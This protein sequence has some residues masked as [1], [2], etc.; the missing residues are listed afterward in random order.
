MRTYPLLCALIALPLALRPAPTFAQD[1]A[2]ASAP[3]SGESPVVAGAKNVAIEKGEIR[4]DGRI[5]A[6]TGATGFDIKAFSFTTQ[7]GK[8]IEFD[9]AKD[10]SIEGGGATKIFAGDDLEKPLGWNVVKLGMRVAVIGKDTGSGKAL[11]VRAIVLSDFSSKYIAGRSISASAPVAALVRKGRQAFEGSDF[12]RAQK[13]FR[14]A[15][16]TGAG[17][18]DQSGVSLALSWEGSTFRELGQNEKAMQSLNEA[19]KIREALGDT[20]STGGILNNLALIYMATGQ[21]AQAVKLMERANENLEGE[22]EAVVTL[23][24]ANLGRAY[25]AN[26]QWSSG[27]EVFRG[28]IGRF[29]AAGQP[30]REVGAMLSISIALLAQGKAEEAATGLAQARARIETITEAPKKAEALMSLA[31]YLAQSKDKDGARTAINQAIES[32][33]AAGDSR[34]AERARVKLDTPDA[35]PAAGATGAAPAPPADTPATAP[36]APADA[37]ATAP[38]APADAPVPPAPPAAAGG[39]GQ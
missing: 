30:E 37:P 15:A 17:L 25:M 34:S 36:A 8:L 21:P 33:N 12:E 1:D 38:A 23:H 11:Q 22:S 19:L 4:L 27:A 10:K 9:E 24:K 2:P 6:M 13:L 5:S 26:K 29:K 14:E 7:A 32:F 18:G 3:P 28:L 31:S 39:A 16:S 20:G 35:A